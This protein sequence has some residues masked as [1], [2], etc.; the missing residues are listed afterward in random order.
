MQPLRDIAFSAAC[1]PRQPLP[2]VTACPCCR[3][4]LVAMACA[5]STP[6]RRLRRMLRLGAVPSRTDLQQHHQKVLYADC[7]WQLRLH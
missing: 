5:C 4:M 3:A 1:H 7:D 2:V 6:R